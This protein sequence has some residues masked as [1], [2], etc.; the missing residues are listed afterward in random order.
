MA[1]S[2][3]ALA[4]KVVT[5]D[6]LYAQRELSR[7]VVG[8][9]GDYFWV[10]KD[11]Q[12]TVKEAIS[13]LFAEPPWGEEFTEARQAGRHGNRQEERWLRTS[14]ALNHYL[15]WPR[16]GQVCCLERTRTVKGTKSVER[17]YAI[18]S[19][20]PENACPARLLDIWRNHWRIENQ[21]HWVRDVTFD[22]DRCQ[23][24]TDAAPQVMAALRNL[25][26]GLIRRTGA[27]NVAAALRH[28]GWKPLE[29]LALFG[30]PLPEN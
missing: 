15:E 30:L 28:Y 29:A 12:P 4:G 19:L 21:V 2:R 1:L 23:I 24:R 14:T 16:V 5:G 18:T 25:V 27:T 26:M 17:S 10:V 20:T 9:G 11:N 7:Y 8:R 6:A 13:L 3:L 22:E